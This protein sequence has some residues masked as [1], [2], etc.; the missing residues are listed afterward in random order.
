M[1]S[2]IDNRADHDKD[3][4]V[5]EVKRSG[6]KERMKGKEGSQNKEKHNKQRKTK[7]RK[8]NRSIQQQKD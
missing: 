4:D 3:V 6:L 7:D 1:E 8:A 5:E 2:K